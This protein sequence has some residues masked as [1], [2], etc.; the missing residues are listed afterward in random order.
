MKTKI[1]SRLHGQRKNAL[2]RYSNQ[3]SSLEVRNELEKSNREL[4]RNLQT[5]DYLAK[6]EFHPEAFSK[7]SQRSEMLSL[8]QELKSKVVK[9]ISKIKYYN[10]LVL[11]T[12]QE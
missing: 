11:N 5:L 7:A 6:L 4:C 1:C 3:L 12:S 10:T 2:E 9:N 8:K